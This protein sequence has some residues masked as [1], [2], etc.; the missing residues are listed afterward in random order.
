VGQSVA[1]PVAGLG[2][3][4]AAPAAGMAP[5]AAGTAPADGLGCLAAGMAAGSGPIPGPGTVPADGL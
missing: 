2:M 5:P 3:G 1:Q 4:M